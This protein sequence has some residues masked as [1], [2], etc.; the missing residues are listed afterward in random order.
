MTYGEALALS[1]ISIPEHL[2]A[3]AE[4]PVLTTPQAQGDLMI[5]PVALAYE[6]T[7]QA[8]AWPQGKIL[9]FEG[10]QVVHGEAT[11]NTHWLHAGFNSPG[12]TWHRADQ[13]L[14]I[15]VVTVPAGQTAMLVHTDEHGANGIG[16]GRYE[17]RQKRELADEIQ[18]V[19]D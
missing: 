4:V 9:P 18:Y 6:G 19:E 16:E 5:V 8:P 3:E 11:G 15:G 10:A 1:K 13:D 17:I 2:E 14:V 12:V 7:G